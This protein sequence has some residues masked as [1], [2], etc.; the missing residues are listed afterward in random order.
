VSHLL[1]ALP[2]LFRVGFAGM[3]AYRAEMTIWI[4]SATMPLIMLA[5]WNAVAEGGP[6]AGFGQVEIARYFVATLVVRQ[7]TSVWLVWELNYE[8]RTGRLSPRLLKPMHPLVQ[9]A[10]EMITALPVRLVVLAPLVL[11]LVLW[12]PELLRAPSLG[13]FA[14]FWVSL[15]LA[16]TLNFLIQALFATLAFW[17]D[18]TDAL[19]GV[20]FAFYTLLSGYV[21]PLAFFPAW[22]EPLLKTL[23]F[24]GMLAVPVEL[25]GGFLTA[26]AALT[27][28]AIQVAWVATLGLAVVLVWRRGLVRYGAFGA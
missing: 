26:E 21:A 27:D 7:L 5:L 12:R 24:R 19:F 3:V 13:A 25:L 10:V 16:W 4:L 2:D 17:L 18:K 9:N 15:G 20:W 14:L 11:A 1:R 23:P 6:V 28:L 8:I 22:S